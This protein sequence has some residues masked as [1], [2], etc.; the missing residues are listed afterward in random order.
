MYFKWLCITAYKF[1]L[2]FLQKKEDYNSN[3]TFLSLSI[4]TLL[5]TNK[6]MLNILFLNHHQHITH[7]TTTLWGIKLLPICYFCF[8][9]GG[10]EEAK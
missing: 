3:H 7:S 8:I 9:I 2:A 1:T 6:G 10:S 4:G 5:S